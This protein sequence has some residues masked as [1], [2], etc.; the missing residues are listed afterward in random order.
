MSENLKLQVINETFSVCKVKNYSMVNTN[1]E[2]CFT[3]STDK[4][5]SLVCPINMVPKE[6]LEREDGWR[7]FRV[8]GQLDFSLIGI[9]SR[10][11][12]VLAKNKIGI[13]VISTFDTDYVF[14]KEENFAK[15][16]KVL[17]E[18]GYIFEEIEENTHKKTD[19]E[20]LRKFDDIKGINSYFGLMII[21]ADELKKQLIDGV[22]AFEDF[23]KIVRSFYIMDDE[24][25]FYY[26]ISS[27]GSA[28]IEKSAMGV[29]QGVIN[30]SSDGQIL[31]DMENEYVKILKENDVKIDTSHAPKSGGFKGV[32]LGDYKRKRR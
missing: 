15:T 12:D 20:V 32:N 2:F 26:E 24:I 13:F 3:G 23:Y 1:R 29:K 14:V 9:I 18:D 17:E 8:C 10:I 31:R 7:G 21:S 6:T 19:T 22:V 5:K 30:I 4:E 25:D 27:S 16:I 11:S 28:V